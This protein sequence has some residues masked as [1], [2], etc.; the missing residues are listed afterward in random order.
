MNA[1]RN[2]SIISI[3][4]LVILTSALFASGVGAQDNAT[5]IIPSIEVNAPIVPVF[6]R[7]FPNGDVTWDVSRLNMTVGY[8]DGL[9]SFGSGSNTVLGGHSAR[10][11]G[12]ADVFYRLD[13]V[14]VGAE[15]IVIENGN[16][17]HY[18]VSNTYRVNQYD[19]A[20]IYPTRHEQLTL[21]TCDLGSYNASNGVYNDRFVVV[22][23]PSG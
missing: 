5:I 22:A 17:R 21:M 16:E 9:P 7:A 14:Q 23:L 12:Q 10:A 15:V 2:L 4:T 8:F 11:Q 1:Q 20:P 3:L 6:V 18:V 13:Q 19:L